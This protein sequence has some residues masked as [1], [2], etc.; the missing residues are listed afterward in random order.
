MPTAVIGGSGFIG[1]E[2]VRA[3]QAT[4]RDVISIDQQRVEAPIPGALYREADA[5][6]IADLVEALHGADSVVYAA[7]V[8][9]LE[10]SAHEASITAEQNVVG[11]AVALE[12]AHSLGMEKFAYLSSVYAGGLVGGFYSASKRAAEDYLKV[13]ADRWYLDTRIVRVG[14]V[15]GPSV[16]GRSLVNQVVREALAGG[17]IQV[18]GDPDQRRSYIHVSDV[19]QAI[20]RILFEDA[21]RGLTVRLVG[22]EAVTLRDLCLMACEAIGTPSPVIT[23]PD[24]GSP[25]YVR[26]PDQPREVPVTLSL[27]QFIDL[28]SGIAQLAEYYREVSHANLSL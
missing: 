13:A 10:A 14:S 2:L 18:S 9:D 8:A 17:A 22:E 25:H 28:G 6:R 20:V 3:L 15:Y 16:S 19:A 26:V 12:A 23:E 27:D 21:F 24:N 4:G 7:G 1:H 11:I 5:L